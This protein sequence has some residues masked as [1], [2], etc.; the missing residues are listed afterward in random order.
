MKIKLLV[1]D[2]T[3]GGY[4]QE[5]IEEYVKRLK[6]YIP[7][8]IEIIPGIKDKAIIPGHLAKKEGELIINRLSKN[9]FVILLDEKGKQ[10]TSPGFAKLVEKSINSSISSMVFIVG[11]A[12]G[13][14]DEVK[15]KANDIIAL[16]SMT[17]SHQM[18][19]L[20]FAEQLYRA[21]TIIRGERYHHG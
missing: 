17:F 8:A 12:Y 15:S 10:Y 2:K 19:R 9:D 20:F 18:I 4:L 3:K 16:S 6:H 14:S 13:V 11:G 21:M 7:F 5:G 1:V